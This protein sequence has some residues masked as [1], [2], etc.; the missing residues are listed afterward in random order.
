MQDMIGRPV[1]EEEAAAGLGFA[2]VSEMRRWKTEMGQKVAHLEKSL[3]QAASDRDNFRWHVRR[4]Q[5]VLERALESLQQDGPPHPDLALAI[6]VVLGR[7][8]DWNH[9]LKDWFS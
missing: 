6:R 7:D 8:V 1:S 5:V 9:R 2:N 4:M 3:R